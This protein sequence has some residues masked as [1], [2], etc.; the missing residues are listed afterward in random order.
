MMLCANVLTPETAVV[1]DMLAYCGSLPEVLPRLREM[2]YR[3]VELI[4]VDPKTLDPVRLD[5]LLSA[6]DMKVVAINTGRLCGELGM[7]ISN[8]DPVARERAL[9]RTREVIDFAAYW[10]I[11]INMGILRGAYLSG[12]SREETYRLTVEALGSLCEYA[13]PCKVDIAIETVCFMQCNFLNTLA[14]SRALIQDVGSPA[15]G[16]MYDLFQ[17]YIEERD[18]YQAIAEFMPLCRHV[19]FADSN[20]RAPGEGAMDYPKLVSSLKE[21]GYSGPVSVEIRPLPDQDAAAR[22]AAEYVLPLL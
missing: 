19:H 18:I 21:A 17:M 20:R 2:G 9:M 4:T 14:E 5:G 8:P 22:A 10:A 7:T 15:L 16:V 1:Q 12:V 11:P 6:N 3:G 13:A